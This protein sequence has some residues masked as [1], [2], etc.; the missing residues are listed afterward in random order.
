MG[1]P[2]DFPQTTP[3][4]KSLRKPMPSLAHMRRVLHSDELGYEEENDWHKR[5]IA[6]IGIQDRVTKVLQ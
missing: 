5:I 6:A 1:F 3:S 2:R 4:G